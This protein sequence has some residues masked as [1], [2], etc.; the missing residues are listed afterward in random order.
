MSLEQTNSSPLVAPAPPAVPNAAP[1]FAVTPLDGLSAAAVA[2]R[3]AAGQSNAFHLRTSRSYLQ[4]LR[5]HAFSFINLVLF[6]LG[7]TLVAMGRVDEALLTAGMVLGNVIVGVGQEGRAKQ[8]L[9]RIAL[10]NRPTATVIREGRE[11]TIDPGEIVQGDVVVVRAGDQILVDGQVIDD[12]RIDVDESLLTGESDHVPKHAGDPVYSGSFCVTGQVRFMAGNVGRASFANQLTAGAR[13]FRQVRTPLQRDVNYIVRLL[14]LLVSQLG[15]LIALSFLYSLIP[16]VQQVQMG[17]VIAALVPQGLFAMITVTYAMGALRM[18][19][20]GALIQQINAVESLS[21]VQVM[22]LDKTGTLTTNTLKLETIRP[23]GVSREEL[24]WLLGRFVASQTDTNRTAEAIAVAFPGQARSV[25]AE[26]PFS[27]VHKWSALAVS[28]ADFCGV[29]VLG[30]PE[31]LLAALHPA[32]DLPTLQAQTGD[33]AERGLRV[34]LFAHKPEVLPLYDPAGAPILPTNLAPLGL[35][36]LRD[37]LRPEAQATLRAFAEAGV[38]IK[39]ISGDSPQTVAALARQAGLGGE[40]RVISGLDLAAMNQTQVAQAA[41]AGTIF[42]RITPQQ[43][44]QLVRAL[45]AQG[46]YVGMIGD[47][48]NDVLSLKQAQLA[49]AMQGGS[50]AT[51]GVADIVLLNDSFA[52]LP[53]AVLE[54]QRIIRGMQDVMRLMLSHTLAVAL[55]IIGCAIIEVAFPTT[56]KLRTIWTLVTV[57]LPT[58]AIATWARPGPPPG[59]VLQP[60]LRFVLPAAFTMSTVCLAVYLCY[61]LLTR[62][63]DQAR[64]ALTTTGVFCGLLLIPF[65][66]PPTPFWVAGDDLSGDWRPSALGVALLGIYGLVMGI[67][68]VRDFFQLTPLPLQDFLLLGGVVGVWALALRYVWRRRVFERLVSRNSE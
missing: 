56:P 24:A 18:A 64:A 53:R 68:P 26:V 20:K 25:A 22:C 55:L 47:G 42:G 35:L 8:Q 21:N 9:D 67:A 3:Q 30:A 34:L 23:F 1:S 40:V 45:R 37:E 60:V 19:G 39:I 27:S 46:H 57:G 11:Q 61:L 62:D 29:Y 49:I 32:A 36:C 15:V 44:E 63:I 59:S 7:A 6:A 10:L 51:R 14:V 2:A 43:K 17:A 41:S 13:A 58:L 54:G 12:S 52:V 33:W 4:I 16:P 38:Q 28:D 65:V 50:Q 31:V 48:V 66:E 5:Q